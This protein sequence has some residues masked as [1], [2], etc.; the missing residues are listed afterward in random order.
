MSHFELRRM[1]DNG[2]EAVIQKFAD[3]AQ[4]EAAM[5]EFEAR[6]HKQ[7]YW[8]STPELPQEENRTLPS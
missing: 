6:G 8:V 4:A 7:T 1:D 2:N 3:L 5:R